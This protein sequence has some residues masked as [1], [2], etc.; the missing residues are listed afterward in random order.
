M[1]KKVLII[2]FIIIFILVLLLVS[3][4]SKKII[5]DGVTVS[6]DKKEK[7]SYIEKD[8]ETGE[9]VVYNKNTGEIIAR[10][11][12]EMDVYIYTIDP[13]YNPEF[14]NNTNTTADVE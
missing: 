8:E 9:F 13:E 14:P 3:V 2:T 7:K 12:N 1:I 10:S 4:F 11:D 6:A 5:N